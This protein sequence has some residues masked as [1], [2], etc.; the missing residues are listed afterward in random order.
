MGN[1]LY[2]SLSKLLEYATWELGAISFTIPY[3][4]QWN[5][6]YDCYD[7]FPSQLLIKIIEIWDLTARSNFPYNSLWKSLKYDLWLLCNFLCN[8]LSKL[9]QYV[10]W[11]LGTISFT[12]PYQN[13]WNMVYDCYD[14]FPLQFLI[15]VVAISHLA[16]RGNFLYSSLAKSL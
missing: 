10:T 5:M 9:L 4:N 8:S 12:T 15:K 6:I 7:P 13:Q 2:N 16:A 1:F 14:P 11:Q 3:R